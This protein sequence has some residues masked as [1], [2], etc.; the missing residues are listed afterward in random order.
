MLGPHSPLLESALRLGRSAIVGLAATFV[1]ILVLAM[2]VELAGLPPT[3]ANIPALL[4]GAVVQFLGLRHAVFRSSGSAL[5][6]Q[7]A[8]FLVAETGTLA[9]NGIAFHLLMTFTPVPYALARPLG[10]F[11]V[12]LGFS[13]PVWHLVFGVR[14]SAG[15]EPPA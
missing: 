13:Y 7:L 5:P 3:V 8:G 6:R 2:L 10:T 11:L 15:V 14:Q 1:D 4:A 12:F 9:L